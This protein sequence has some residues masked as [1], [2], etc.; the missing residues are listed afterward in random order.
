M[1]KFSNLFGKLIFVNFKKNRKKT[2]KTFKKDH[3]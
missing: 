2:N 1:F 3:D